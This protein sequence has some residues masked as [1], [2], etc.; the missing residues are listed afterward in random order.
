[1]P[2]KCARSGA[3]LS[4]TLDGALVGQSY[5]LASDDLFW[6]S[7]CLSAALIAV[8]WMARRTTAAAGPVA[9]D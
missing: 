4:A 3:T 1:M 6:I 2:P 5:L 8:I 9:S 7:G